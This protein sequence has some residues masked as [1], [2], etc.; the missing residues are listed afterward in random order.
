[1][2]LTTTNLKDAIINRRSIRKVKKNPAITKEKINE[3]AKTA[4]HAP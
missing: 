4:L 1:M 3:I 2:S